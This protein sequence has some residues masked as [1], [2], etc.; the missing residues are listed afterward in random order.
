MAWGSH[1]RKRPTENGWALDIGG[2][3]EDRT[4]DLV[5]ANDALSQL[6]YGPTALCTLAVT[7][8]CG[9]LNPDGKSWCHPKG[10]TTRTYDW[11][12]GSESNRR[13]RICSPLHDHSA[14]RPEAQRAGNSI[15]SW[16]AVNLNSAV[17]QC[18]RQSNGSI[19][20][21]ANALGKVIRRALRGPFRP[22]N[23][24]RRRSSGWARA[25][26]LSANCHESEPA[27]HPISKPRPYTLK[28]IPTDGRS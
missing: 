13:T 1:K 16:L 18:R 15:G 28:Q 9:Q 8:I 10:R 21:D 25:Y 26:S 23:P 6:S 7:C 24:R 3:R 5:I 17:A 4:P 11:R 14:T 27:C 2:A 20:I 19:A 22:I 12:P